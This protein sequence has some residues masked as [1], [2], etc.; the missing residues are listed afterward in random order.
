MNIVIIASISSL[1]FYDYSE[2]RGYHIKNEMHQNYLPSLDLAFSIIFIFE[3]ILKIIEMGFVLEKGTYLR[4]GDNWIY[5][6][7]VVAWYLILS[8]DIRLILF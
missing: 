6:I 3:F 2:R 8:F 1:P 4:N 5:F 7:I